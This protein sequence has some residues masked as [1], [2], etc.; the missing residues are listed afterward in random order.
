MG[1]R[2]DGLLHNLCQLVVADTAQLTDGQLLHRFASA[3]DE[4]AFAILLQRHARLVYRVCRNIVRNDAAAEDAFQGT[5]LVLARK[6]GVIREWEAVGSW[7]YRVAYR[8][9]MKAKKA[10]ERRR[11]QEARAARAVD[12]RPSCELVWREL[13]AMLDE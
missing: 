5:F 2:P 13:Q 8:V 11:L 1:N 9:A 12:E 7:L 6:A 10:A 3:R 4:G